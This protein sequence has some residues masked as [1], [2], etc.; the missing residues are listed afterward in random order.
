MLIPQNRGS[1]LEQIRPSLKMKSAVLSK[2]MMILKKRRISKLRVECSQDGASIQ[3]NIKR[4]GILIQISLYLREAKEKLIK[5]TVKAMELNYRNLITKA[6]V[7]WGTVMVV[8]KKLN[9]K[10]EQ[11]RGKYDTKLLRTALDKYLTAFRILQKEKFRMKKAVT[12]HTC[13]LLK[14]YIIFLL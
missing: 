4:R 14:K 11:I 3:E 12:F 5:D 13:I 7:S 8:N 6:F 10:Y 2:N 9:Q 1:L